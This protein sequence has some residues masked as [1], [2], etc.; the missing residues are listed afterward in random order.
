MGWTRLA[1][2]FRARCAIRH[3]HGRRVATRLKPC[4]RHVDAMA[5]Q[6]QPAWSGGRAMDHRSLCLALVV[7]MT[8]LAVA[9]LVGMHDEPGE[10]ATRAGVDRPASVAL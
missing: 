9:G 8:L 4:C 6:K 7:A 1:A 10:R 5:G 2:L 3:S